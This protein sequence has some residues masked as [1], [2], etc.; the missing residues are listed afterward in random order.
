MAALGL[1][2]AAL[3]RPGYLTLS[4]GE[5]LGAD[6]SVEAMERR[7]WDVCDAAW[8]GGVRW[9]DAARS[10][11]RAEQF[12]S[13]WLRRRDIDPA[14]ITVSSKWGYTYTADWQV[15]ADPPEV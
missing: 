8:D 2:L 7:C 9:F 10:Y 15:A 1:G 3:G 13:G 14:D 11:G 4:H 6:R 12:L 5:D